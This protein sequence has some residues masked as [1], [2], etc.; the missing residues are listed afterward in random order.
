MVE[1]LLVKLFPIATLVV[2]PVWAAPTVYVPLGTA[3]EIIAIDAATD[4]ITGR[5]DGLVNPHGLAMTP[6]GHYLVAGSNQESMPGQAKLPPRP[7]GMSEAEHQSHHTAPPAGEGAQVGTSHVAIVSARDKKI[8]RRI[9]VK[10]AVH[11]TLVTPDGH[12]AISTHTTAGGISVIDMKTMHLIKTIAT[13]PV[14]NYAAAT[15]DGKKLYVSNAGNNTISEIDTGN[16]IVTRN[17]LA[18]KAPEHV[19]LSPDD[20]YLYVNNIGGGD[21]SAI[22]LQAG[23]VVKTYMVGEQP[24]GIDISADGKTLFATSRQENKLVAIDI[25]HGGQRSVTLTPDP[26]HV[27]TI[28]GT[29]KLFVSSRKLPKIWVLDQKTLKVTGEIAIKG[30]GHQMVVAR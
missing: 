20:K 4:K 2:A 13:G 26:Y 3:N 30:E 6:D 8:V 9:D 1:R 12:Y 25:E 15:R 11:H 21:I 19:V 7:Q 16:W 10:G 22:D 29:N 27:T 24:H 18:G 28:T 23:K 14:P 17:I 5:I